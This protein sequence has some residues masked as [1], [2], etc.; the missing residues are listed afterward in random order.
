MLHVAIINESV[1]PML[2]QDWSE[3]K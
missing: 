3:R 1:I 2:M